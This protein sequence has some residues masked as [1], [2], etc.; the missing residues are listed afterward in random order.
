MA[1]ARRVIGI[2]LIVLAVLLGG[3]V[4]GVYAVLNTRALDRI[5]HKYADEYV[6]GDVSWSKIRISPFRNFPD[7][8]VS[9]DSLVLQN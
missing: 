5:V 1:R 9:I 4:A 6:D 8:R 7:V 2:V 3:L